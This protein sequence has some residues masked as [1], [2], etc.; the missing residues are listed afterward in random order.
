MVKIA[1]EAPMIL[2]NE[3]DVAPVGRKRQAGAKILAQGG[4]LDITV[5]GQLLQPKALLACC[6]PTVAITKKSR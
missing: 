3:V 2:A 6:L 1:A 4:N 5:R